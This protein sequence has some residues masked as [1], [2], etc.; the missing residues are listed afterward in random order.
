MQITHNTFEQR[1]DEWLNI[2]KGKF[3]G[4][5][6]YKLMVEPKSKLESLSETA[7]SYIL[8]KIIELN[9]VDVPAKFKTDAM[10]W[11]EDNEPLAKK[12]YSK[13]TGKEIT[14]ISFIEHPKFPDN[15]G[16]SPDGFI[17]DGNNIIEVKCPYNGANH[18]K[19]I[20]TSADK[21]KTD[22]RE[23]YWQMQFY[24]DCMN[25]DY[26]DF[27]S[28]DKRINAEWGLHIKRI[29]RNDADIKSMNYKIEYAIEYMNK[30]NKQ[31]NQQ[32]ND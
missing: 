2:R 12:W 25:A 14:E 20:I 6:I 19:H 28:F 24:I 32:T 15:V 10:Q 16:G 17:R 9:S 22:I 21:F 18:I 26:C 31:L 3:T 29:D 30:I 8:E 1:S 27:I 13:I 7:K 23:Y 11:G 4:S 5:E